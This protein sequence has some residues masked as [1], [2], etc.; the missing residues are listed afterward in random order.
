LSFCF[1]YLDNELSEHFESIEPNG[2]PSTVGLLG[3]YFRNF[4]DAFG[5]ILCSG[6]FFVSISILR[7]TESRALRGTV[8][9]CHVFMQ[10][11][12][13]KG[14]LPDMVILTNSC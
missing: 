1:L 2:S 4:G 14:V 13:L 10:A 6:L 5:D 3:K 8:L 7:V 9:V 11:V 12:D